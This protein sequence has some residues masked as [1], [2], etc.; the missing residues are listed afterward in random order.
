MSVYEPL[1]SI[2]I[3]V[4]NGSNYMREAIDSALA[5]TYKNIEII[6][7]NDGSSDNNETDN[8]AK[9]YGN[10]IRYFTKKNGGCASA[11]NYGIAEMKGEWF[12][13]LS[14]DDKYYPDKIRNS[15]E[16]IRD[17]K[18][19]DGKSMIYCNSDLMDEQGKTIFHPVKF[20][21]GCLSDLELLKGLLFKFSVNGCAL[22]IHRH[23][24]NEV[25]DFDKNLKY[26]P[27]FDY[28]IRVALAGYGM[29]SFDNKLCSNRV[30]D[31][32]VS[33]KCKDRMK[34]DISRQLK[35]IHSLLKNNDNKE[36]ILK[37]IWLYAYSR[38]YREEATLLWN[39]MEELGMNL[40]SINIVGKKY[41]LM[42][43][44]EKSI[45]NIYRFIFKKG[46]D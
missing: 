4:Y 27:D 45:K 10:K 6:V 30:H 42:Y 15:I 1:V 31:R 26:T 41:R 25:G 36:C 29:A 35:K 12:S 8:I 7:V 37:Y 3:P 39:T 34:P 21:S 43:V 18:L 20:Y 24:L 19:Q 16:Y 17:N 22:L 14:H 33:V 32:Q 38:G 5:Q 23:I 40:L 44:I 2:I 13:W 11:L 9:S 46:M 28:W